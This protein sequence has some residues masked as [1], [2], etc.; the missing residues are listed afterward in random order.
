MI[1]STDVQSTIFT[2]TENLVSFLEKVCAQNYNEICM[3]KDKIYSLVHKT[4][5]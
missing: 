2:F 5:T 4:N 1:L 3:N